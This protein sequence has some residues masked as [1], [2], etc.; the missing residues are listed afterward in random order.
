MH[1]HEVRAIS[2][3]KTRENGISVVFVRNPDS[4]YLKLP[5]GVVEQD[6][7]PLDAMKREWEEEIGERADLCRFVRLGAIPKMRNG[8]VFL[9]TIF[10]VE[11]GQRRSFLKKGGAAFYAKKRAAEMRD[12]PTVLN[13]GDQRNHAL[14]HPSHLIVLGMILPTLGHF[15]KIR[16]RKLRDKINVLKKAR[17]EEWTGFGRKKMWGFL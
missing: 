14:I 10:L 17:I 5:G 2:F 13:V 15:L 6:E 8:S 7:K 9:M 4:R 12:Y 16:D 1:N 11:R 3:V